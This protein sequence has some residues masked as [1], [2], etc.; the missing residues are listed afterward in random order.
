VAARLHA[1]GA[2][3][4]SVMLARLNEDD[5]PP[6]AAPPAPPTPPVAEQLRDA[7]DS[8][9]TS[10]VLRGEPLRDIRSG[11]AGAARESLEIEH[12]ESAESE[13]E[14]SLPQPEAATPREESLPE[15]PTESPLAPEPERPEPEPAPS[16]A[17]SAE[18]SSEE[19]P[20]EPAREAPAAATAAVDTPAPPP[21]VAL[22]EFAPPSEPLPP[23]APPPV[24]PAAAPA[25]EPSPERAWLPAISQGGS[26]QFALKEARTREATEVLSTLERNPAA[27]NIGDVLAVLSRQVEGLLRAGKIE[28]MVEVVA[29]VVAI[30]KSIEDP[31]LRRQYAIALKRM[32]SKHL[33]SELGKLVQGSQHEAEA[34]AVLQRAGADGAE[35]LLDLL[36]TSSTIQ[37]RRGIYNVLVQMKESGDQL[38]HMLGHPQWFVVRNVADL[39]GEL[40]LEPAVPALAKALEHSDERVRKAVALALAK[41]GTRQAA[42]PLRRALR[43]KDPGVRIQ[44]ALGV[45][46]RKA[47][48]LAMPLVVALEEEKD[49][50]VGKELVLA[51]GR[52]AS[53]DSVQALIKIAQPSGKLFGRKPTALRLNAVEALRLAATPAALGT[54]QGLSNDGD[55]QVRNAAQQ[56]LQDLK[57]KPA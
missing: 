34:G 37:E 43:D 16:A 44:A 52:I 13:A 27:G 30:E 38:V 7:R 5:L 35:V 14:R 51:L 40:G 8:M 46:G 56:A 21:A 6:V 24:A 53:P 31:N 25:A 49:T 42:E 55:K 18:L 32:V 26:A 45:N 33:L 11:Q 39:M 22:D 4:V 29:G 19:A 9:G 1:S 23:A 41:I 47:S 12:I 28:Q 17:T 48:A 3:R 15:L 2:Y 57:A 20:P 10:G 50:E 36:A 54:L